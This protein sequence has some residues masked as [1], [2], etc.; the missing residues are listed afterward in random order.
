MTRMTFVRIAAPSVLLVSLLAWQTLPARGGVCGDDDADGVGCGTPDNCTL[1]PNGPAVST[2][3][4]DSQEDG[5]MDGYGNPCDSDF[6]N[7]GATDPADLS[8]MLDNVIQVTTNPVYDLNCNG[9]SDPSDLSHTLTDTIAVAV[10]GPSDHPC[11][12]TI[13]CP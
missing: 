13:P 8:A 11:A 6:N 10:P 9:A 4:C 5:D 3:A 1:I 2:G 12:G 7:N